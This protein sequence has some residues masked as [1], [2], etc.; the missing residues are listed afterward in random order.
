MHTTMQGAYNI[1]IGPL[2]D[3]QFVAVW[4]A[5]CTIGYSSPHS[6]PGI[7]HLANAQ[8][9]KTGAWYVRVDLIAVR[10]SHLRRRTSS[11]IR[12]EYQHLSH[13]IDELITFE[14]LWRGE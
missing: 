6:L 12:E 2:N 4:E 5:L 7:Q 11:D 8:E 1:V 13:N 9:K 10:S 3:W 14:Q